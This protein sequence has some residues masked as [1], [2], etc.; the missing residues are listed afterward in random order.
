MAIKKQLPNDLSIFSGQLGI[1]PAQG[2]F[3]LRVLA[4][5]G[6]IDFS[7]TPFRTALLP[8]VKRGPEESGLFR[9]ARRAKEER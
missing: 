9:L 3:A 1:S 4:Q 8:M 2:A 6:L 5:I 7:L